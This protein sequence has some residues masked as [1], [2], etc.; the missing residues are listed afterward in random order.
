MGG[1][2]FFRHNQLGL[3]GFALL[4]KFNHATAEVEDAVKQL[5]RTHANLVGL[6]RY[7]GEWDFQLFFESE[8]VADLYALRLEM[9]KVFGER[10]RRTSMLSSVR[11]EQAEWCLARY[12]ATKTGQSS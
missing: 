8:D 7:T 9:L 6:G 5:C 11:L 10:L 2:Y 3:S 4:L 12:H 1:S